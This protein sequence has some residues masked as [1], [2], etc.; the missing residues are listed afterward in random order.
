LSGE[1]CVDTSAKSGPVALRQVDVAAEVEEGDL[2]DL[3][4]GALGGYETECEI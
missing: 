2:A 1:Q 4:A 3:L